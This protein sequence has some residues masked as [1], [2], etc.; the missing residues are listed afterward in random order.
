MLV[1]ASPVDRIWGIGLAADDER[2][3]NPARWRGLNL[4]GFALVRARAILRGAAGTV[5]A[6]PYGSRIPIDWR[7][8]V[9]E[10]SEG[11]AALRRICAHLGLPQGDAYT[12]D[13]AYELGEEYRTES[14][15]YKYISAYG[16]AGYSPVER[17]LL[18]DLILDVVNDLL[19]ESDRVGQ[20][21]W[22]ATMEVVR[23]N[24]SLHRSQLESW[25][26]PEDPLED[27]YA[28][29]PLVRAALAHR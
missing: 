12:Q 27:A 7:D 18:V 25:A 15:V 23:Q 1:E 26:V 3:A 22:V 11:K 10:A 17:Q 5:T 2:A 24:F 16:N 6:F 13:W 19:V 20:Q 9:P 28:I 8:T 14:H 29:T 21:A 4:L